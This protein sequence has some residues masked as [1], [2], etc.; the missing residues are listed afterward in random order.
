MMFDGRN[1]SEKSKDNSLHFLTTANSDWAW[2]MDEES[3]Y[4]YSNTRVLDLLGYDRE[5]IVGKRLFD[6]IPSSEKDRVAAILQ[7]AQQNT[8]PMIGLETVYFHKNGQV[9]TL[10]MSMTPVWDENRKF[11]G[12]RGIARDVAPQKLPERQITQLNA[13]SAQLL[14]RA[15]L[16]EKL[17]LITKAAVEIYNAD[18]ARIWIT[19]E[20][21]LCDK[22]CVHAGV[23][24]EP[25]ICRDRSRCLHLVAG[26]GRY[27][28]L[29]GGH[30]R[31]PL[32][33]YKIGHIAS[34]RDSFFLT[35]DVT[36][37]P[38]VHNHDWAAALGLV[39]FVGFR[40]ISPDNQPI[41]VLALF[42]QHL[43]SVNELRFLEH[44]A[45]TAAQVIQA[46][47]AEEALKESENRFR[48]LVKNSLDMIS[49]LA[50]DGRILYE[51]PSVKTILGFELHDLIGKNSLDF[52]HPDDLPEI[53]IMYA[54]VLE[55]PGAAFSVQYRF[56]RVDGS[57]IPLE[58]MAS[59]FLDD[60]GINGIVVN[61][62]DITERI[63]AEE[64]RRKIEVQMQEVQKLESL[65][66]LA[67]GIA[68]DFNNLLM[69]I[70][71]NADL[72]L[73]ALSP[74]SLARRNVE[75]IVHASQRAS[76]LCN[77]MLAY[78]GK[79]RF[80]VALH[81]ISEIVREM[82][83]MLE[84][85]VTKRASIRYSLTRGLPGV[86]V[87][88]TQMR[89]VI[90][91]LI[92]NASE[93]MGDLHGVISI[94]TEVAECDR[95][96]LSEYYLGK[97]L[98][99]GRYVCLEV[100]DTG[101]GMDGE[102]RSR[103]FEPFYT[104][105]FAG[106]GLGLAAVLGIIRGHKGSIKVTSERGKGTTFS[107]L[108]PAVDRPIGVHNNKL[109]QNEPA[110]CGGTVL[111]IDDD[112]VVRDVGSA[113]LTRLGYQV[114]T[115]ADGRMGVDIFRAQGD[116]IACIILDLTMPDMGGEETFREL[117]KLRGD[118]R[119]I[120]SSGF[121]EQDATNKFVGIGLAG[122]IQKPYSIAKLREALIRA[123][124]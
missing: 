86:E 53:R 16:S 45:N 119:V 57:Y 70:L 62:R 55:N 6:L 26:S 87:D 88:A 47:L 112:A 84:V 66:I 72:A 89:Q 5:E 1:Q 123:I 73:L 43:V 81:D 121:D 98:P 32:G 29:D 8:V 56:K 20:G 49:V 50:P 33:A 90:L 101:C 18:F 80:V 23:K 35:N 52:I 30:R 124:H 51:S 116:A 100:A 39:S 114:L 61:S 97:T 34:G 44:L 21:D 65:G 63:R 83:Q 71:G 48:S 59:S 12:Y 79:G 37:D 17:R 11:R 13:L 99:E 36:H 4:T 7:E 103:I 2:E 102:T 108:L 85:S 105:K 15:T 46:G 22:G 95:Q 107:I 9:I 93:S 28:H 92:T 82:G 110:P 91:N 78:S 120:L 94:T 74:A 58:S 106:R 117:R 122:F 25:H 111:F 64:E 67:G 10:E 104:T 115:A 109:D 113:M 77:Q 60:P 27:I 76:E 19:K 68:H 41:G 24:E 54:Q 96:Y 38:A 31:V 75:E 69:A 118:A 40:L 42:N 3:A 14:G